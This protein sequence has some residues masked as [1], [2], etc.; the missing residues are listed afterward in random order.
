MNAGSAPVKR[1]F[2][3]ASFALIGAFVTGRIRLREARAA[4]SRDWMEH[5][6]TSHVSDT[7][8]KDIASH[9]ATSPSSHS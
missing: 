9:G 6:W 1:M 7:E 3:L 4:L 5:P 8:N 2:V